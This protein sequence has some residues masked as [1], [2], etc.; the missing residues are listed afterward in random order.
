ML[1]RRLRKTEKKNIELNKENKK[2]EA[3]KLLL[4]HKPIKTEIK[5]VESESEE[6]EVI[7]V[8]KRKKKSKPKRIIVEESSSEEDEPPKSPPGIN[9]VGTFNG[10]QTTPVQVNTWCV[11]GGVLESGNPFNATTCWEELV[12]IRSPPN[13]INWTLSLTVFSK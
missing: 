8:E 1:L 2:V 12:P 6:E 7:I 3:A 10:C 11:A 13:V 9:W 5:P 4:N